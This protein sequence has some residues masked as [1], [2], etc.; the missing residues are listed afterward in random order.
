MANPYYGT[1]VPGGAAF[2]PYQQPTIPYTPQVSQNM[3][4]AQQMDEAKTE[5]ERKMIQD[6][7]QRIRMGT[8]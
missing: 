3:Q 5:Y 7:I 6:E 2:S 8:R 4:P 1:A